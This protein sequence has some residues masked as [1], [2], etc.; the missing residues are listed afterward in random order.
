[1]SALLEVL[2]NI[3]IVLDD[4]GRK[5]G[6]QTNNVGHLASAF[7]LPT[8]QRCPRSRLS[9]HKTTEQLRQA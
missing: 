8:C 5:G 9:R 2:C 4:G 7:G 3:A 6:E 1:M